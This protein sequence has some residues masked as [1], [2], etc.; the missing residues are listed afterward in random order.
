MPAKI[1]LY[2]S[3]EHASAAFWQ[4]G[5][6]QVAVLGNDQ[7]GWG[8]FSGLLA[9]HPGVPVYLVVDSV[10]EE[11]RSELVPHV[12]GRAH[13]EML[14]RKL[15]QAFRNI[16]YCA[17]WQQGR[18]SG[19]RKDDKFLFVALTM[20]DMLRAWLDAIQLRG[21]P[22]AGVYLLPMVTQALLARLHLKGRHILVVSEGSGGLR[23]SFFQDGLLKISRLT[24]LDTSQDTSRIAAYAAEIGKT[25]LF[26]NSQRLITRDDKVSLVML[27]CRNE[28]GELPRQLNADLGYSS[29][30]I[31]LRDIGK[32]LGMNPET[33]RASPDALHLFMLG[34]QPP[35]VSLAPPELRRG[36]QNYQARRA[37]YA[38]SLAVLAAAGIWGA[39]NF[40]QRQVCLDDIAL[41]QSSIRRNEVLYDE[42]ARRFPTAP[43]S[44]ENL[45]NTVET[46]KALIHHRRT[47]EFLMTAVSRALD[48]SPEITL[49][50]LHWK[51]SSREGND[52]GE[53]SSSG[54]AASV[55]SAIAGSIA[56]Q[57]ASADASIKL[58]ETA[59]LEGEVVPFHTDYRAAIASIRA[60]A[61]KLKS[62]SAVASVNIMALP[63]DIDPSSSLK[64]NTLN[65]SSAS[66][67]SAKFKLQLML[68]ARP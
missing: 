41:T 67:R 27:D 14:A 40:Y 46:A 6:Q 10:E 50:R 3:A 43:A 18:D 34:A 37:I 17:S 31:R 2:V 39:Y 32:T 54:A 44:A 38:I 12:R 22:L 62:D 28:F 29:H 1:L 8:E 35:S 4:G 5:L 51:H 66:Q 59:F 25:R 64:G 68:K 58:G 45:K 65:G 55:L 56:G 61:G 60:F 21:N 15:K 47:P 63:L 19:K 57:P 7:A 30:L 20:H 24:P 13:Q 48:A 9:A 36:F 23:Q 16:S 49:T 26:L 42:I 33:L 11:F 52:Q 53:I